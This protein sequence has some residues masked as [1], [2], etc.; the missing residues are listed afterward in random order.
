LATVVALAGAAS[1][2][3][4]LSFV[5]FIADPGLGGL[6]ATVL[7]SV[8]GLGL[9]RLNQGARAFTVV[10]LWLFILLLIVGTFNPFTAGDF[11]SERGAAPSVWE[12]AVWVFPIIAVSIALLHILGKYRDEFGTRGNDAL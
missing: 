12:L 8:L 5:R 11:I 6:C 9:W 1:Y 3:A 10:G 2:L 7:W 4:V